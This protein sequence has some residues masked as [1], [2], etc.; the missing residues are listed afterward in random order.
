LNG[1]YAFLMKGGAATN[2][3]NAVIG[4]FTANGA[5]GNGLITAGLEDISRTT[6]V[7]TNLT[8][9]GTYS[10]GSDNRGCMT[11]TNSNGG[12]AIYRIALGTIAGNVATQ[13]TILGF[14][15]TTGQGARMEG[16]LVQQN[17]SSF[18]PGSVKGTY[19]YGG[20]GVDAGGG[21][22]A[23]AELFTS[24][25]MSALSN[26]TYDYDDYFTGAVNVPLTKGITGSYLLN[27]ATGASSGRGTAA[28]TTPGQGANNFAFYMVSPS[29]F[30]VMSTDAVNAGGAI[31]SGD[32]RLQTGTFS[33]TSLDNKNYVFYGN[34]IDESNGGNVT[35]MGQASFT[36]NGNATL[37][38]DQNDNGV[39]TPEQSLSQPF[40]IGSNGRATLS[41]GGGKNPVFYLIDSTQAFLVGTDST[42]VSGYMQQQSANSFS[43][44]SISASFFF[45]GAAPNTGS[46]YDSGAATFTPGSVAIAGTDDSA[47]PNYSTQGCTGNCG[48]LDPNQSIGG[49][50][51]FSTSSTVPGQGNVGKNSLA[52]IISPTKIIF[53]QTGTS[54]NTNPAELFILQ[55]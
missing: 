12:T 25:G 1:Q 13:G 16:V 15:D 39:S 33:Q 24:D 37:T 9:T 30:L 21:R 7:L 32:V 23:I 3:Y 45:G 19:V 29:E 50:Y 42:I 18:T 11:L 34:A 14:S 38:L 35:N 6:G 22:I 28:V 54:T 10:I 46:T 43:T 53:I 20:D 41:G 51:S 8:L 40:T 31:Q 55:H 17:S 4:S 36:T 48:G 2:G 44:S 26:F 5:N 27:S 49:T 52:Y 47:G